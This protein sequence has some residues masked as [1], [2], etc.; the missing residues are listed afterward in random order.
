MNILLDECVPKPVARFFPDHAVK[1]VQGIGWSGI[2]NGEL[3]KRA[4]SSFDLLITSD[5]NLQYQQNLSERKIALLI[6][7]TNDWETLRDA[8]DRI[9]RAVKLSENTYSYF[10]LE[11]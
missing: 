3:I 10:E 8:K 2:L 9:I 4:E 6:L 11:L 1:T 7:P 5:K